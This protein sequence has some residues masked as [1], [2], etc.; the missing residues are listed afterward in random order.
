MWDK[1]RGRPAGVQAHYRKFA[2]DLREQLFRR[3]ASPRDPLPS[4]RELA[5][6]HNVGVQVVRQAVKLLREDGIL[7]RNA[8]GQFLFHRELEPC[9]AVRGIVAV[10]QTHAL[11]IDY[12]AAAVMSGIL[13]QLASRRRPSLVLQG[14]LELRRKIPA[15]LSDLPI[16]GILLYGQFTEEVLKQ[17]EALKTPVVIVDQPSISPTLSSVSVDNVVAAYDATKRLLAL[18]HRR[19]ALLRFLATP[20]KQIDA[21]SRERQTG[22]VSAAREARIPPE[23]IRIF[24]RTGIERGSSRVVRSILSEK[25]RITGVLAVD[26]PSAEALKEAAASMG[27][28]VPKDVSIVAFHSQSLGSERHWSGPR[29]DLNMI[30]QRAVALA[31]TR[32]YKHAHVRVVSNW[33]EGESLGPAPDVK[34]AKIAHATHTK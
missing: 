28:S 25:P 30:G 17:Y 14:D 16:D 23:D 31:L 15:D 18:G 2:D 32:P 27:L 22:F 7:S 10:I 5:R 6:Q 26:P 1:K 4:F 20:I 21:D 13:T 33:A 3:E 11:R 34:A 19:V 29:A 24:T 12:D 8:R 9:S